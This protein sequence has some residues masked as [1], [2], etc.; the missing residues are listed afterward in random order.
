MNGLLSAADLAERLG[1]SEELAKRKTTEQDWPCVR[2]SARTIRYREEHVEQIVARYERAGST[3]SAVPDSGQT[4]RS[5]QRS[6]AS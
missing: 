3:L 4:E 1:I 5:K 2:F 6:K